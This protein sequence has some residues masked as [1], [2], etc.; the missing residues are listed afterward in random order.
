MADYS[1]SI[2]VS[3]REL[4]QGL[5]QAAGMVKDFKQ[6]A[7][8]AAGAARFFVTAIE[9]IGGASSVA[10]KAGAN[11]LAGF[12][13]GGPMGLAIGGVNALIG[14]FKDLAEAEKKAAED[15]KKSLEAVD[16]S[17]TSLKD[18]LLGLKGIDPVL[19]HLQENLKKIVVEMAA[20]RKSDPGGEQHEKLAGLN[21]QY[22]ELLAK[23]KAYAAEKKKLDDEEA[24]KKAREDALK[25]QA[26]ELEN[27]L[28]LA[29]DQAAARDQI[30]KDSNAAVFKAIDDEVARERKAAQEILDIQREMHANAWAMEVADA[31]KRT[32]LE[33]KQKAKVISDAQE[34]LGMAATF[35]EIMGS[36]FTAMAQGQLSISDGIKA[37]LGQ[38]AQVI[39]QM[40]IRFEIAAATAAVEA[41]GAA[42]MTP[43]IGP[44]L[45]ISAAAAIFGAMMAYKPAGRA[46]GG[47]VGMG[48]P[49]MV[50]EVGPELFVPNSSGSIVPNNKLGS[51]TVINITAMDAKSF[52]K[53]LKSNQGALFNTLADGYKNRRA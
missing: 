24:A 14:Y 41:G 7:G 9:G 21:K 1:V 22:T 52:E 18:K 37:M 46:L 39:S 38:M 25:A 53:F 47:P 20:L 33:E 49:Y 30:V 5:G 11:L 23:I 31:A 13:M 26:A 10:G 43:F 50:G 34:S 16:A 3:L 44:I 2:G 32:A 40:M 6:E 27:R 15:W 17:I 19:F 35:G 12:A 51:N 42:A 28:K 48:V 45:A 8:K 4:Q 29:K 36:T